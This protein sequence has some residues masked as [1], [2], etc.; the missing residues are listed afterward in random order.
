M[1][2]IVLFSAFL[3]A[4]ALIGKEALAVTPETSEGTATLQPL[5]PGTTNPVTPQDP[6]PENPTG[7][8]QT[9]L[10]TLDAV[11]SFDFQGEGLAGTFTD[12]LTQAQ[13]AS[14][15]VKNAQ[16]TDRRG[17]GAGWA[18]SLNISAFQNGGVALKGVNLQ[19]PVTIAAGTDNTS[20]APAIV[21]SISGVVDPTSG[22]DAGTIVAAGTG[23][24]YGTWIAKFANASLSIADGNAAGAYKSTF[25]W[26]LSDIPTGE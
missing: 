7:T 25:T 26:T 13:T 14:G 1:K 18:L 4:F 2:K 22:L 10:L 17:T 20:T 21:N 19:M 12:T 6:D 11:P 9:G 15:Y 8:G 5:D 3:G 16:V 23:E 24:G